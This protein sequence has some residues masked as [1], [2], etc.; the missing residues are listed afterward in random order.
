MEEIKMKKSTG[1]WVSAIIWGLLAIILCVASINKLDR[2]SAQILGTDSVINIQGTVF[3][4]ACAVLCGVSIVGAMILGV[5][6]N[7]NMTSSNN[8]PHRSEENASASEQESVTLFE[9]K[10]KEPS[11]RPK[12]AE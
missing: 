1:L 6:E 2:T 4:A 7:A 8:A 5:L 3:A 9:A 10:L 11:H 12:N